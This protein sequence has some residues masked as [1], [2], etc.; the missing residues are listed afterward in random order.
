MLNPLLFANRGAI[1][2]KICFTK[3]NFLTVKKFPKMLFHKNFTKKT[4]INE[5]IS[6]FEAFLVSNK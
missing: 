2:K 3:K 1:V 5:Y 4:I 6:I